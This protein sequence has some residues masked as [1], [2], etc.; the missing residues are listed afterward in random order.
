VIKFANARNRG[1]VCLTTE[2]E[3]LFILNTI[4][5]NYG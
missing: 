1:Q 4:M 2:N 5:A 3:E